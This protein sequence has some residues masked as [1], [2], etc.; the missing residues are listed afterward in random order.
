MVM[1]AMLLSDKIILLMYGPGF[2]NSIIALQIL[3]FDILLIFMYTTLGTF[4]ISIDKQNQMA[5]SAFVTAL[6]N[7]IINIILI[8]YF[9]Y[10]GAAVTTVI[11]ETVLFIIYFYLVS[12]YIC[13]LPIHKILLKPLIALIVMSLFI[14]F[15][16]WFGFFTLVILGAVLYFATLYIIGGIS[17]EDIALIKQIIQTRNRKEKNKNL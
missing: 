7:V 6:V 10:V 2:T 3:S 16:N 15:F 13:F 1:G 5:I 4:L 11:C 14:I 12:K 8:P 17:K 9:S